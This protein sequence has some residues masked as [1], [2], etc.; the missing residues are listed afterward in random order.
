M[1]YLVSYGFSS[2]IHFMYIERFLKGRNNTGGKTLK[3]QLKK[4]CNYNDF[5]NKNTELVQCS[6]MSVIYSKCKID[7]L[8]RNKY[9]YEHKNCYIMRK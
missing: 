3:E 5:A 9:K 4:S 1:E 8:Y 6:F 7:Y 2:K